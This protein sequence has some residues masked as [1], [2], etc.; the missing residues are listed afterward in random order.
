MI[1][2][3]LLYLRSHL[4]K[5]SF[6]RESCEGALT[7]VAVDRGVIDKWFDGCDELIT[8]AA[9][10]MAVDTSCCCWSTIARAGG[11]GNKVDDAVGLDWEDKV[12]VDDWGLSS[13]SNSSFSLWIRFKDS[14]SDFLIVASSCSAFVLL[15]W[16]LLNCPSSLL[17]LFLFFSIRSLFLSMLIVI[18]I[19]G[20]LEDKE[21][22]VAEATLGTGPEEV[23]GRDEDPVDL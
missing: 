3:S 9:L 13:S 12:D 15:F 8:A 7:T 22:P 5:S 17:I 14:S 11:L 20:S 21:E 1:S 19:L 16:I 18:W 10:L 4:I 23:P 2:L 6:Q